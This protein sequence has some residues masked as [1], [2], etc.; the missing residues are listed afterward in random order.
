MEQH[1]TIEDRGA[2]HYA[3]PELEKTILGALAAA[4]K[5]VDRLTT[6]DLAPIDEF[7]TGGREATAEFAAQ[8]G[9]RPDMHILDIGCGIGGSARFLAERYG[10]RVTGIDI[11][12][13]Y[14]RTA[15]ALARRVGLADRVV[16]RR[17]SALALPFEPGTF[18]GATM[19]HVGM[20][21]EDKPALFARSRS[22]IPPPRASGDNPQVPP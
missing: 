8:L 13:D 1:A 5:D 3:Q 18:D 22:R 14:V 20:N 11:T 21:I 19:M 12:D 7:H 6:G 2:G 10:C 15:E 9:L 17:A 16:Y 4:G